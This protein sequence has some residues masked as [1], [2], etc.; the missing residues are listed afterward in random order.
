MFANLIHLISGRPDS[1]GEAD[2]IQKTIVR[3][4]RPRNRR[5][6]RLIWICWG[7]IAIKCTVVLWAVPRYHIP[8][9]P[10]WVIAPTIAFAALCTGVYYWRR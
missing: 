8:F 4:R 10:Y 3:E 7:L 2:F 1:D 6:E 9:S 5:V